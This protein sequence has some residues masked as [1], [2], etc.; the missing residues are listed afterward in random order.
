MAEGQT[1]TL[2]MTNGA[3]LR[4]EKVTNF[5]RHEN[6]LLEFDYV[7]KSRGVS[8]HANFWGHLLAGSSIDE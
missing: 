4:F 8:A 1:L 5:R 3:T 2:Y 7:S 6:G